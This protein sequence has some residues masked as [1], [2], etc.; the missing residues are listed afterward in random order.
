MKI[1]LYLDDIKPIPLNQ[2]YA[3][4]FK[5]KLRFKSKKYKQFE[6][7][8]NLQLRKFKNDFNKFNK[9]Y[10]EN[11]H[12]ISVSYRFYYPLLTKKDKR[13]SKTSGD[14]SNLIKS[15]EDI[16]FKQLHADDS[17]VIDVSATKIHST[18]I[19]IAVDMQVKPLV[20]VI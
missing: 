19:R 12:Y 14:V 10:D 7:A 13:I 11:N 20:S 17:A 5:T 3:T 2:V 9:Y 4:D 15:L 6:S 16:I 8:V 18:Q 1:S